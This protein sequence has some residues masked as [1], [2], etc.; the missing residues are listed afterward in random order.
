[1]LV[2]A[3]NLSKV[4][5]RGMKDEVL[6]VANKKSDT[7]IVGGSFDDSI[8]NY[9]DGTNVTIFGQGGND[10]I[11]NGNIGYS[12]AKN[13]TI[14]GGEGNDYIS[15]E[16]DGWYSSVDAGAG[17]DTIYNNYGYRSTL[18]GGAGNDSIYNFYRANEVMI[19]GGDGTDTI[20]NRGTNRNV[21]INAGEG[22]DIIKNTNSKFVSKVSILG[23]AGND[24]IQ[25][26]SAQDSTI[27]GGKGDDVIYDVGDNALINYTAGDGNDL[28]IMKDRNSTI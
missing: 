7:V 2:G 11:R 19:L 8:V 24:T 17:N 21:T 27:E 13:V 1:M 16:R 4:N 12:S 5:V 28:I 18:F 6:N 26:D 22:N 3:G 9:D 25:N 10:T 20:E 23:G 15:N 14:S